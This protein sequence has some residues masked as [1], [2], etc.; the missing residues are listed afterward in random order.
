MQNSSSNL[1][2]YISLLM[3]NDE[4]LQRFIVDPITDAETKYGLTKAERAVLRRTVSNLSHHAI[5][6]FS[7]ERTLSSYRR[8]LRLLQNVLHNTGTKMGVDVLS[9]GAVTAT[10]QVY[11]LVI[12]YPNLPSGS[13]TD[14]TCADNAKVDSYGGPYYQSQFFQIVFND[15]NPT[16]VQRLLL[17]AAQAFPNI[18]AYNSVV[19]G[20]PAKPFIS[21]ISINGRTIKADISNPCY[22]LSTN[23][24]ADSVFWFYS[25]NGMPQKGFAGTTG[26]LG[27]SFQ[28]YVLTS[29]Q[30]VYWQVLAPDTTYGFKSCKPHT[31]NEYAASESYKKK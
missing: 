17:G 29:G 31:L 10:S 30:T 7:M 4:A 15:S 25:I 21:E 9:N 12:N 6:G 28:D 19:M 22:D 16:T 11:H 20:T 3:H 23:P 18:I 27:E 5:N 24:N 8:S 26:N 1:L 14:F 2:S 13:T